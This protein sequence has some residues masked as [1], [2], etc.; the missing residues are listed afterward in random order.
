MAKNVAIAIGIKRAGDLVELP[1]AVNGAKEFADWAEKQGYSTELITDEADKP[2]TV[3]RLKDT[4]NAIIHRDD[5]ERLLIYF[6]GHGIQ[7]SV[8]VAYWLLSNWQSDSDE[9]VNVSLSFANAKRTALGQI[10]VFADAC[11]STVKDAALVG[12]SSIFPKPA[13]SPAKLPQWDQFLAS[14]LGEVSQ[15]VSGT[16]TT[17]AYGI[18]TRCVMQALNGD[19]HEAIE[20]RQ[21]RSYVVTSGK[22]ADY[23]EDTV[24]L[25][26]GK[27][28]G[29]AVQFP[30]VLPGWRVPKDVYAT[31]PAFTRFEKSGSARFSE[32]PSSPRAKNAVA[33]AR[34][35]DEAALAQTESDFAQSEGR[36][37]FETGQG[38]TIVGADV[39]Q[40][41]VGRSGANLFYENGAYHVRGFGGRPQSI[42]IELANGNWIATAIFPGFVGTILVSDGRAASMNYVPIP[43]YGERTPNIDP[44]VH[45][46]NAL[47]ALGRTADYKELERSAEELR[48]YKHSN[49]SLGVL[50]AYAYERAGI[51]DQINDIAEWFVRFG[52]PIPFDVAMLSTYR[53]QKE[54]SGWVILTRSG[55]G[56][57]AGIFPLMT[58]GWAFLEKGNELVSD[59][60]I[61][62]RSGLVA[63]LWTTLHAE[64]ASRLA[65]FIVREEN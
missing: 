22:L 37:S 15:E 47:M 60:L 44:L 41:K 4:I 8:N 58:Q 9:A 43:G 19:A 64:A 17:Q 52:Q 7:P 36:R 24:P 63:S 34:A 16:E 11:R 61:N 5:V 32:E 45:R 48:P 12:G 25:E 56:L 62:A 29:A 49:P 18:F 39:L 2:V 26:S 31:F 50:A 40:I 1:G 27:T 10:S 28:P 65:D 33:N 3:A 14:R 55:R 51:I 57:I 59:Y 42:L 35:R 38:L 21:D 30:E 6:A 23:L 20:K 13:G 46:W 54:N 53:V